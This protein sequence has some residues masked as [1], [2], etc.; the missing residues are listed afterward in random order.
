[1]YDYRGNLCILEMSA[2]L[3]TTECFIKYSELRAS[4]SVFEAWNAQ[5]I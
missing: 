1:M 3:I 5:A 4:C 2:S